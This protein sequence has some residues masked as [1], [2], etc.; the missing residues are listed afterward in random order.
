MK[1]TIKRRAKS[2]VAVLLTLCMVLSVFT[3]GIASASAATEDTQ[4][5]TVRITTSTNNPALG[6][7]PTYTDQDYYVGDQVEITAA[8]TGGVFKSWQ[9]TGGTVTSTSTSPTILTITATTVTIKAVYDYKTYELF[10]DFDTAGSTDASKKF[11]TYTMVRQSDGTYVSTRT[12]SKDTGAFTIYDKSEQKLAEPQSGSN[13]EMDS[14]YNTTGEMSR[15]YSATASDWSTTYDDGYK[16]NIK[17]TDSNEYYVVYDPTA[18]TIHITTTNPMGTIAQIYAKDGSIRYSNQNMDSG[19]LWSDGGDVTCKRGVT[20]VTAING[21]SVANPDTSRYPSTGLSDHLKIYSA[22]M[23]STITIETTVNSTDAAKG[24]YV[25][26]FVINGWKVE[27]TDVGKGVYRATYTLTSENA[28]PNLA[29]LGGDSTFE[30]TPVYYNTNFDYIT[31]YVDA[32][33]VPSKWGKTISTCA[34]Y[35]GA[36]SPHFE[37]SYPGQPLG[38]EGDMYEIKVAKYY[39][40]YENSAWVAQTNYQP[41]ATITAYNYDFVHHYYYVKNNNTVNSGTDNNNYQTYDYSDFAYLAQIDGIEAIMF[42]CKESTNDNKTIEGNW[43]WSD[44]N[45]NNR[46]FEL[47]TDYYG[48]PIDALGNKLTGAA[49]E[50]ALSANPTPHVRILSVGNENTN[51]RND[52]VRTKAKWATYWIAYNLDETN[53]RAVT[54]RS[55]PADFINTKINT[56]NA[57]PQRNIYSQ[58]ADSSDSGQNADDL[59]GKV[60]FISYDKERTNTLSETNTGIRIDGQWYY[61]AQHDFD[62]TVQVHITTDEGTTLTGGNTDPDTNSNS[63]NNNGWIGTSSGTKATLDGST[64]HTY[65]NVTTNAELD[66]TLGTGY[67][68]VGWYLYDSVNDTYTKINDNFADLSTTMLMKKNYT[69][70]AVVRAVGENS[71]VI[72]HSK[73]TGSKPEAHTGT[74]KYYVSAKILDSEDNVVSTITEAQNSITVPTLAANQKLQIKLRTVCNGADTFYAWYEEALNA[75]YSRTGKYYEICEENVDPLGEREVSYEFFAADAQYLQDRKTLDFYSDIMHVSK[76]ANITYMYYD[77]FEVG[78]SNQMVSYTVKNVELSDAEIDA[79]YIP[80]DDKIA[81]YAPTVVDTIYTDTKWTLVG[82]KVQRGMSNVTVMATQAPKDCYVSYIKP[83]SV[84]STL[85]QSSSTEVLPGALEGLW[86]NTTVPFNQ[87]LINDDAQTKTDPL[88]REDF[89]VSA[90]QSYTYHDASNG[91]DTTW[92]F[93][94][95]DVYALDRTTGELG[96][97]I[98]SSNDYTYAYRI[99]ADCAIYPVYETGSKPKTLTAVIDPAVLNREVY[100]DSANPTDKLYADL[101]ISYINTSTVGDGSIPETIKEN[102]SGYSIETGVI[103]DKTVTLSPTD[104]NTLKTAAINGTADTTASIIGKTEY[105]SQFK[106]LATI[107][108]L[109]KDS[110]ATVPAGMTKSVNDNSK[111]TTMNRLD[112]VFRYTNN[113]ANQ[114]KVIAAYSYIVIRNN[115]TLVVYAISS[116]QYFN[117]CYIGNK[118]LEAS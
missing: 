27:A 69:I 115:G 109:A 105:T 88:T 77:R 114:K 55:T 3:V 101:L 107:E 33:S 113:E 48:N 20:K 60:T 23:G 118:P 10:S 67:T 18:K 2:A 94:R 45:N 52:G 17:S 97:I 95:F 22:A 7:V 63:A 103:L 8:P 110:N 100:G 76:Y 36:D 53:K 96:G 102:N 93:V 49:L 73:Y 26:M 65:S 75:D 81:K 111:L 29:A 14:T 57:S 80:N 38:R 68:F 31:F 41:S 35:S 117:L 1:T 25:G 43:N 66:C 86:T 54:M 59:Q 9:V 12:V 32:E 106:S 62:S 92:N 56:A 42:R 70:A 64:T 72:T 30:I 51:S 34:D 85:L 99:Y 4:Q 90:P 21:S 74:G 24:F 116:P 39:Y 19:D 28:V 91:T 89:F 82:S 79:G 40:K 6:G 58:M 84:A 13:W 61:S 98:Y 37:G 104:Y 83:E 112:K 11:K 44:S 16:A 5:P 108:N 71:L 50:D 87:L 78:G 15:W 47:L 46:T